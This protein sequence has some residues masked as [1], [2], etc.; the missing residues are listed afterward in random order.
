MIDFNDNIVLQFYIGCAL[1]FLMGAIVG[2][3]GQ[4]LWHHRRAGKMPPPPSR[5]NTQSGNVFFALFG[6]VALVGVVGASMNTILRGP[7]TGMQRVT[8]YTVAENNMIAAG[9]LALIAA[10]NQPQGGDCDGDDLVEPIPFSLTGDGPRPVGGGYLPA[11]IG[12]TR[13]DPW[14]NI[15]GYC[16]WDHGTDP[17]SAL[18]NDGSCPSSNN[19]LAGADSEQHIVLAIISAGPDRIFQTSCGAHPDYVVKPSGSDDVVLAYTYAEAGSMSGGL[20]KLKSGDSS[21]AEVGARNVEIAGS[22]GGAAARIGYDDDLGL[23]GVGEFLAIKTDNIYARTPNGE[24]MMQSPLRVQHVTGMLEIED[25]E[26][27]GGT[28]LPDCEAGSVL[29]SNGSGFDCVQQVVCSLNNSLDYCYNL[30]TGEC[31]SGNDGVHNNASQFVMSHY[32]LAGENIKILYGIQGALH[33]TVIPCSGYYLSGWSQF[34]EIGPNDEQAPV[35]CLLPWGGTV[36]HGG[37]VT[38]F[39]AASVP[40]G[41]TCAS[42]TRSCDSGTLSGSYTHQSCTVESPPGG[43]VPCWDP[44]GM[45]C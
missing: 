45:F 22:S 40:Y 20:W 18:D 8:K 15:F 29:R 33:S 9:K 39:Q 37:S 27:G 7:V 30:S 10:T 3:V 4:I 24:V 13:Q 12:A 5:V 17:G 42:Q 35:A 23:S 2:A 41:S 44:S 16:V 14:G 19:Y 32:G 43:G 21:T 36:A 26:G 11:D 28:G 6:A 1:I 38:A 25:G 31:F 34:F